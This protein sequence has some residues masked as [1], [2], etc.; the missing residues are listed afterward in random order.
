MNKL[1]LE[2]KELEKSPYDPEVEKRMDEIQGMLRLRVISPHRARPYYR[3]SYD[4]T[5]QTHWREYKL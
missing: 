3:S 1:L 4:E 2:Y 5:Q